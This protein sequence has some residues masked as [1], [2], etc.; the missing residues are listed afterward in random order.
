MAREPQKRGYF[1]VSDVDQKRSSE[2]YRSPLSRSSSS[3]K[4]DGPLLSVNE[5]V[6]LNLLPRLRIIDPVIFMLDI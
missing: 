3:T 5:E 4:D 1:S 6:G 2:S